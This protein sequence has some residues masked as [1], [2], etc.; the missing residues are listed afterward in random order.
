MSVQDEVPKSRLT[1]TYKTEVNG[2]PETVN[3]PFR[4]LVTGDFS[5]GSSTDRLTDLEERRTRSLDG[6]NTDSIMK[7]MNI[8]T[9]FVVDNKIDPANEESMRVHLPID[10]MKSFNPN[11][12]A[13]HIPKVRSLLL[14]KT[15]LNEVQSNVAN[16]KEFRQ[17]LGQLYSNK[18]AFDKMKE[19]IKDYECLK[20]PNMSKASIAE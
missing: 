7:D 12:V 16:K 19:E 2:E 5:K 8:S 10:S 17:L 11:E 9:N 15:L 13:K 14:L 18:D 1:L 20:L 6:R 3:L 4:M